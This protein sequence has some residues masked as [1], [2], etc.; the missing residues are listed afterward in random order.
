MSEEEQEREHEVISLEEGCIED[1]LLEG[2]IVMPRI[3][4]TVV[5]SVDSM[6]GKHQKATTGSN[7]LVEW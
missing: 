7:G 2:D 6:V 4:D 5:M 1:V 3:N